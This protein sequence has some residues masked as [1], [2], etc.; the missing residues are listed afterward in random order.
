MGGDIADDKPDIGGD[1]PGAMPIM[2]CDG[3]TPGS[4]VGSYEGNVILFTLTSS[5]YMQLN[6]TATPI[7]H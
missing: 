7:L 3:P 1:K 6:I 2:G 4:K 5:L